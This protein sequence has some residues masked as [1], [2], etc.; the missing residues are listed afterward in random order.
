[1]LQRLFDLIFSLL[2]ILILSPLFLIV[3]IL[4]RF[5]GEGEIFFSQIRIGKNGVIFSIHKFATMLKNSEQMTN[6]TVTVKD[7]PRILP[8]GRFLRKSKINE[9]PQLFNILKGEMSVIGPRPQTSNFYDF[10]NKE[11]K[12]KI[13]SLRPGLS[14]IGSIIFRNE[15]DVLSFKNGEILHNTVLTPYKVELE[16]WYVKNN[17]LKNYFFLIFTTLLIVLFPN[18]KFYWKLFKDLPKPTSEL[19]E[20]PGF[21]FE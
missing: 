4:L 13:L 11:K 19:Q 7:D 20:I 5:T 2:A 1:M 14:G 15:E 17:N 18:S 6:G 21:K 16:E 10:I 3:V 12:D 9:L 8:F